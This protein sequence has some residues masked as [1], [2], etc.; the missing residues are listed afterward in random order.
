[1]CALMIPLKPAQ[2]RQVSR[3]VAKNNRRPHHKDR[4]CERG[5]TLPMERAKRSGR[6]TLWVL[7]AADTR[8]RSSGNS[9]LAAAAGANNDVHDGSQRR[10]DHI[11]AVGLP[12][13][14]HRRGFS[15]KQ[16]GGAQFV[17][18]DG[19]V[20]FVTENIDHADIA[21]ATVIDST[22]SRLLGADDGGSVGAY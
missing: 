10:L 3:V 16:P 9:R 5:R 7:G 20:R 22:Y 1:M 11:K 14:S 8:G 21:S 12:I 17:L 4:V 18:V 2:K 19:A 6:R 13:S 15:S